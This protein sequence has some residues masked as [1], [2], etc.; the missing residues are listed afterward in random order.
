[1]GWLG[2]LALAGA[3]SVGGFLTRAQ[4]QGRLA[5]FR[6]GDEALARAVIRSF[7][8]GILPAE[9]EANR[10]AV[11]QT[12]RTA[13][14]YLVA[15]SPATQG[16]ARQAL[17]LMNLAP[18]RWLLGVWSPW[19]S[20]GEAQVQAALEA[21]RTSRFATARQIFQLLS[22]MATVGWYGQPTS[23]AAIGYPGPPSVP[24]PHGEQP[25]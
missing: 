24:R 2:S 13:D 4:A 11:E 7:L 17:G 9:P 21:L 16:E 10:Q 12:L 22:G 3:G 20:A 5:F 6:P 14:R 18:V 1:V 25:L 23:W 15:L 19:T 8:S